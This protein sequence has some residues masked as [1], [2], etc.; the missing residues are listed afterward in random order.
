MF[1]DLGSSIFVWNVLLLMS[2]VNVV[3]GFADVAY[4][5]LKMLLRSQHSPET[6]LANDNAVSG[7]HAFCRVLCAHSHTR[8][9]A[10]RH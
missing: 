8:R 9:T 1:L 4:D 2:C 6:H 5:V 10:G 3:T 7:S